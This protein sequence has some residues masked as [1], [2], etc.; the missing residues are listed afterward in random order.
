MSNMYNREGE[1]E[2]TDIDNKLQKRQAEEER[3]RKP[4][5]RRRRKT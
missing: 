1:Q 3:E 4:V 5:G 2:V